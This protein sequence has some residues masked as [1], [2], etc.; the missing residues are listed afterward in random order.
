MKLFKL[1]RPKSGM[2]VGVLRPSGDVAVLWPGETMPNVWPREL[3]L[4]IFHEVGRN[5]DACDPK[6]PPDLALPELL[7]QQSQSD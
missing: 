4:A 6:R 1:E 7:P 3:A 5:L 2:Q